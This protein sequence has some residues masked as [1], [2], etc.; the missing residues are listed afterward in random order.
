MSHHLLIFLFLKAFE[1]VTS[2]FQTWFFLLLVWCLVKR[3]G[4]WIID[5]RVFLFVEE[6]LISLKIFDSCCDGKWE[7]ISLLEFFIFFNRVGQ[8]N[9]E[10]QLSHSSPTDSRSSLGINLYLVSDLSRPMLRRIQLD[11]VVSD[12]TDFLNPSYAFLS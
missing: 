4:S 9:S 7:R 1:R 5:S 11:W 3:L 10:Y 8:V 2:L 6:S 12:S